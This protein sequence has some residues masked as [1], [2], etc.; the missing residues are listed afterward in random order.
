MI[1]RIRPIKP[2]RPEELI[3]GKI[4][5]LSKAFKKR[6][7]K[8]WIERRKENISKTKIVDKDYQLNQI[9]TELLGDGFTVKIF[10]RECSRGK[11]I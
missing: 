10:V 4:Y 8:K 5:P 1:N 11:L 9:A 7:G 3:T 6:K 2:L